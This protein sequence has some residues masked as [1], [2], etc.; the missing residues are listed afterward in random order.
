MVIDLKNKR[1]KARHDKNNVPILSYDN[2]DEAVEELLSDYNPELLSQPQ[3]IDVEDFVENYLDLHLHYAN[4]SLDGHILGKT[5]FETMWVKLY[6]KSKNAPYVELVKA[7]TVIIDNSLLLDNREHLFRSTMGHEGGHRVCNSEYY[8]CNYFQHELP[9]EDEKG[10]WKGE[11]RQVGFVQCNKRYIIENTIGTGNKPRNLKTDQDRLEYQANCFSAS[12][13][14]PKTAMN[15]VLSELKSL[16]E[17]TLAGVVSETFNVSLGS[18]KIRIKD[19]RRSS[20][21]TR[22][23]QPSRQ[24]EFL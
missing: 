23:S 21:D 8:L 15:I 12:L 9:L 2:I 19:I 7:N 14:M 20:A 3:A 16:S 11:E 17:S 24:L 4:L 22:T 6:D 5:V 1:L 18:A 13:L 10:R